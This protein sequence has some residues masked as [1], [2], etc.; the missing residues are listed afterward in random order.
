MKDVCAEVKQIWFTRDEEPK[1]CEPFLTLCDFC[2]DTDSHSRMVEIRSTIFELAGCLTV[3]E[4]KVLTYR[5][6][7][8]MTLKEVGDVFDVTQE[9]IRQLEQSAFR[10]MRRLAY[11]QS[12]SGS[13]KAE[14]VDA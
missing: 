14:K 7:H 9:R 10:K 12:Q 2:Y 13:G 8:D 6:Q 4:V 5:Y 1:P 3:R 11:L